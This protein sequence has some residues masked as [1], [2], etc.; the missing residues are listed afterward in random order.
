MAWARALPALYEHPEAHGLRAL[1]PRWRVG[2]TQGLLTTYYRV[3]EKQAS[4]P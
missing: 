4:R 2:T 1:G 3:Y